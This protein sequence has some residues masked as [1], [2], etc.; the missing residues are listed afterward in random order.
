MLDKKGKAIDEMSFNFNTN[1]KEVAKVCFYS[2]DEKL[3]FENHYPFNNC[4]GDAIN[5]FLEK[6]DREAKFSFSFYIK[7]DS[8]YIFIDEEKL[9]S[10]YITNLHDTLFLMEQGFTFVLRMDRM[11]M[12]MLLLLIRAALCYLDQG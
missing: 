1:E 9:I 12:D 2:M 7:N 5:E 10:Y 3:L 6:Q 4:I 11:F 8:Q